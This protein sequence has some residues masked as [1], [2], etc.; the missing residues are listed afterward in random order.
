MTN[1]KVLKRLGILKGKKLKCV[2]SFK[3][4][5]KKLFHSFMLQ[6][7]IISGSICYAILITAIHISFMAHIILYFEHISNA[8]IYI[9]F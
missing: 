9:I 7:S 1:F 3:N 4:K 8:N 5:K 2:F 6:P